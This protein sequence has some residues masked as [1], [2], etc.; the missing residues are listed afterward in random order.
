MSKKSQQENQAGGQNQPEL[1]PQTGEQNQ[2]EVEQAKP[3]I[4]DETGEENQPELNL[5]AEQGQ[6]PEVVSR[7]VRVLTQCK[8]G[9][10]NDVIEMSDAEI[11]EGKTQGIVDDTPEAVAYAESLTQ[12]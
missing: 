6:A 2:P 7:K 10:A 5:N 12:S 11:A 4:K 1:T 8:H 3:E 9:N